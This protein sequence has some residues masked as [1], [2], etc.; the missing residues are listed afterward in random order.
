MKKLLLGAT[1]LTFVG[2]AGAASAQDVTTSPFNLDI[3]GFSTLGVGYADTETT[4][5][6][7]FTPGTSDTPVFDAGG[8]QIGA[9]D[10][11]T[12]PSSTNGSEIA[13]ITNAEIIFNFSLVAD[14][15]LTFGFKG[16]LEANGGSANMDEYVGFVSGDFG[17]VEIGVEDGTADRFTGFYANNVFTNAADSGGILFDHSDEGVIKPDT[18]GGDLGDEFKISYFSPTIA[19]FQGGISYSTG[20]ENGTSNDETTDEGE[21]VEFA[22]RYSNT[23][24]DVSI[25]FG[26]GYTIYTQ[27]EDEPDDGY[28]FGGVIGYAGFELGLIYGAEDDD[29]ASF[30]ITGSYGTG[31]W[32][33][34]VQYGQI[35]DLK[36]TDLEDDGS[37]FDDAFGISGEVVYTLAPGVRTG[38]VL[39][40]ASDTVAEV[41]DGTGLGT[42]QVD[43]SGFAAGLFLGLSF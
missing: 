31:P 25:E 37:D 43:G 5:R 39:E 36:D 24:G 9:L 27:S 38:V 14:N 13:L 28:T 18:S 11:A 8:A 33:F 26:G 20:S 17:R 12:D 16:E 30:G 2:I 15:G 41:D 7:T 6:G 3:G 32:H 23:F 19:G 4:D 1:A 34:G 22:A 35:V 40:Y 21:G 29:N 42:S 10:D